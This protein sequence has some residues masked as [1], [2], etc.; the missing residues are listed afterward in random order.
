ML[1]GIIWLKGWTA[2]EIE[3]KGG[4]RLEDLGKQEM[5]DLYA[6]SVDGGPAMELYPRR[7]VSCLAC[8]IRRSPEASVWGASALAHRTES[9]DGEVASQD[10]D[11]HRRSSGRRQCSMENGA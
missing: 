6:I 5:G 10:Q 1:Q 2:R 11:Q 8:G 9:V 3:Q 7:I 4:R